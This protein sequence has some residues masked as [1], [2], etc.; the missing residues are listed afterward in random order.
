MSIEF[1][2]FSSRHLEEDIGT[3]EPDK[4]IPF[5][6]DGKWA[7]HE[8]MVYLLA[9]TGPS[10]VWLST[11]SISEVSIR[12]FMNGIDAGLITELHCIF[13]HTIRKHKLELLYFACNVVTEITLSANHSKLI[14]IENDK[15][16]I[17]VIGS[18][19]MTPNPRK[20][21]GVIFINHNTFDH[22]KQHLVKLISEG[23]PVKFD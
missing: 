10:K 2:H 8:L 12:A 1:I 7:M 3:I 15:W 9:F 23:I 14:L 17:T 22:Y 20:E 21:A 13:D 6:S 5:F 16:K 18:A 4:I 11:F 19:N